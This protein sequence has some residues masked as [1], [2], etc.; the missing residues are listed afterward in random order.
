MMRS[1][2]KTRERSIEWDEFGQDAFDGLGSHSCFV[3]D[4]EELVERVDALESLVEDLLGHS[5]QY[6]TGKGKGHNNTEAT[7]SDPDLPE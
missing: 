7:T 2:S 1:F 5:H 4:L 3:V 6:L